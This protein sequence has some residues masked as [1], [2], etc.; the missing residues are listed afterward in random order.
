[1][2]SL[3]SSAGLQLIYPS[4][5][6]ASW[7]EPT[8][9]RP[10]HGCVP[11][12]VS[13]AATAAAAKTGVRLLKLA[14]ASTACLAECLGAHLAAAAQPCAAGTLTQL[15]PKDGTHWHHAAGGPQVTRHS[16]ALGRWL[17]D[18]HGG[19]CYTSSLPGQDQ[20]SHIIFTSSKMHDSSKDVESAC[21]AAQ[22]TYKACLDQKHD[23]H[24][25]DERRHPAPLADLKDRACRHRTS[26]NNTGCT[27]EQWAQLN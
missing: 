4:S 26:V 9:F 8:L 16:G 21:P 7:H 12:P 17:L 6:R 23:E 25:T 18:E 1:M 19:K 3:H 13:I 11:S 27:Q 24:C 2:L 10:Q 22:R 15:D 20:A 14:S 5:D